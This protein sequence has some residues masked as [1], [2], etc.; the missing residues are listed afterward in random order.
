VTND[1]GREWPLHGLIS[2]S[3]TPI[4]PEYEEQLPGVS[5]G[6]ML[7]VG[8][9]ELGGLAEVNDR[10][11][12]GLSHRAHLASL[13]PILPV[14]KRWTVSRGRDAGRRLVLSN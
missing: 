3:L 14:S 2:A 9:L 12:A 6:G 5:R 8:C 10:G 11:R 1:R 4:C 7:G 13:T